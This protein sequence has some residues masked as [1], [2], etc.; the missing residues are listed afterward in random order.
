MDHIFHPAGSAFSRQKIR[1]S[2]DGT[3]LK[4]LYTDSTL[5]TAGASIVV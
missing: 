3:A 5:I 2:L 1:L 4:R